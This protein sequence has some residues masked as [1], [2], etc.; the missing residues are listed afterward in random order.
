[1]IGQSMINVKSGGKTRISG[2]SSAIF[3][4]VF[5]LYASTLI[6]LIPLA[7]LIGVMFMVVIGTFAWNSINILLR[8]PK[9][10]A[11]VII[12]VTAVTV[13]ED[14]AVAVIVGVIISALVYAWTSASKVQAI[15]R[16]SRTEEGAKVYEIEGPLFF[17]SAT[18]F[19]ELFLPLTDPNT[20][21]IDFQKSRVLDQSALQAIEDIADKYLQAGK[22]VKLR[23]LSK[24]CHSL[25]SKSGQLI[26]DSDDDPD[27][28][29]AV[30]YNIK[31]GAFK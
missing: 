30:D 1:M 4:L 18:T 2:I 26:V 23:H 14:L 20:V 19:S 15:T 12:L 25:L 22:T 28:G 3:L 17:G 13:M 6:E 7:A 11:L 21:I 16:Y 24:D 29:L 27:Y 10:D 31:V 5:I 9:S 8:V